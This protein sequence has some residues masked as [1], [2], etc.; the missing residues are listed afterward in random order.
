VH[1]AGRSRD[2][3]HAERQRGA[4]AVSALA[5]AFSAGQSFS[6]AGGLPVMTSRLADYASSIVS[7]DSTQAANIEA[8]F[9]IQRGYQEAIMSRSAAISEVNI[10][11]EMST[12]LVLQ[13]AYQA[14]ARVTQTVSQMMDVLINI[15]N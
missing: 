9:Q 13:N 6:A 1:Y 5:G 3:G 10:D 4:Q 15:L 12:I 14:A 11:E 8:Q 2:C 7:L